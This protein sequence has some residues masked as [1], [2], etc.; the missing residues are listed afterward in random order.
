M[1]F[2]EFS[3]NGVMGHWRLNEESGTTAY[4][5]VGAAPNASISAATHVEGKISNG[6]N[7]DGTDDITTVVDSPSIE[8]ANGFSFT[9]WFR[10][11]LAGNQAIARKY[12]AS[13]SQREWDIRFDANGYVVFVVSSDGIATSS[14]TG[15]INWEDGNWHFLAALYTGSQLQ[16]FIDGVRDGTPTN[17]SSGIFDGTANMNLGASGITGVDYF[18]VLDEH[19][20]YNRALSSIEVARHYA[21]GRF[22]I[23]EKNIGFGV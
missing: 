8:T 23:P 21:A 22:I 19:K 3:T 5:D 13:G 17:Y 11:S 18:G 6:L 7:F 15:A 9:L 4:N 12:S 2:R 20:L 1:K 10:T 14:V 16:L